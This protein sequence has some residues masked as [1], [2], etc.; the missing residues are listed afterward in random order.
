[1]V[2]N[3]FPGNNGDRRAMLLRLLPY[4]GILVLLVAGYFVL[5]HSGLGSMPSA[6]AQVNYPRI[7]EQVVEGVTEAAAEHEAGLAGAG[8]EVEAPG[9][10]E[11]VEEREPEA[12]PSRELPPGESAEPEAEEAKGPPVYVGPGSL[13]YTSSEGIGGKSF[14][15]LEPQ[16]LREFLMSIPEI[17][18]SV[19]QVDSLM[20]LLLRFQ[21]M[22]KPS[23][24]YPQAGVP[25]WQSG[26][27]RYSPFDPIG[28]PATAIAPRAR[29]VPPF[30]P[31]VR[32]EGREVRGPT[33][34]QVADALRLVG[35]MGEPGAYLVILSG[36]GYE[37][38]LTVG[39]EIHRIGDFAYVV[40]D[41]SLGEVRIARVGKP[42]DVGLIQFTPR[43]GS[44]ISELSITY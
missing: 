25:P 24:P 16:E 11:V 34:Q 7:G 19:T 13:Y 17:G 33:A 35:V 43:E 21:T 27:R 37:K 18:G 2:M 6:Q 15:D 22:A 42:D 41:I 38:V 29:A 28:G 3:T 1:M 36:F 39:E 10:A 23:E 8:R 31:L 44:G 5:F 26:W 4:A 32:V 14:A 20:P 40:T 30:P 12:V 9:S